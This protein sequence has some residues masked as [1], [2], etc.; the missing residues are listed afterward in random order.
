M[1]CC[2]LLLGRE[3]DCTLIEHRVKRGVHTHATLHHWRLRPFCKYTG[4]KR[5]T[6]IASTL[7]TVSFIMPAIAANDISR[8]VL[9]KARIPLFLMDFIIK[10]RVL[11]I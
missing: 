5:L 1:K 7:L 9:L 4:V 8:T 11:Q 6:H 2:Q 3:F 10:W